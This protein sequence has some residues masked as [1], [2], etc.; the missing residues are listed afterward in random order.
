M[1]IEQLQ[2]LRNLDN[3]TRSDNDNTESLAN[4]QF[5]AQCVGEIDI[6]D[7]RSVAAVAQQFGS[8]VADRGRQIVREWLD[9]TPQGLL[10]TFHGRK[11]ACSL[12]VE[13]RAG[14]DC[15]KEYCKIVC[16]QLFTSQA[17]AKTI[18]GS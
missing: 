9:D 14:K 6:M 4:S 8:R 15:C 5:Q 16:L 2:N 12:F 10:K 3:G 1:A 18:T 11:L 7:Q 13:L 17:A